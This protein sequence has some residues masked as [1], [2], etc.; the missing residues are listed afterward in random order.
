VM[1]H[2]KWLEEEEKH[3][4]Y[5][6]HLDYGRVGGLQSIRIGRVAKADVVFE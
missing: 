3:Q 2:S 5:S 4:P 1:K 6:R